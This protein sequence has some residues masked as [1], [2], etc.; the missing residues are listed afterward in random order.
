M[1][2][3]LSIIL[4]LA[5]LLSVSAM[6]DISA[7][8]KEGDSGKCGANVYYSLD[9]STGVLTISGTGDMYKSDEGTTLNIHFAYDDIK[10]AVIQNGVT[11][12]GDDAFYKSSALTSVTVPSS[13]KSIGNYALAGCTALKSIGLPEG[14]N[15]IGKEAFS[16]CTSL[17]NVTIPSTLNYIGNSAFRDCG[18]LRNVTIPGSV[19]TIDEFAFAY[20]SNLQ[21]ITLGNGIKTISGEAFE[22][23]SSLT[24]LSIPESVTK[25]GLGAVSNCTSLKNV[26]IYSKSLD[27]YSLTN[28]GYF[29]PKGSTLHTYRSVASESDVAQGVN[30]VYFG[31]VQSPKATKITKLKKGKKSFSVSWKKVNG[32]TG[33]QIQYSLKKNMKSSKKKNVKGA[34][35]TK[36]NVKKL[37]K[38]KKYYVRVRTYK[39]VGGKTYY[40]KW[41]GKESV[42]VK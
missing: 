4:S 42:K 30:V 29:M 33:Y 20:C 10:S 36:L 6:F 18:S 15:S 11:S 25:I 5:M 34:K 16:G 40:S 7:F 32:V 41:S 39:K 13:V 21:S 9:R 37:K 24:S 2:K 31:A 23:C 17:S 27:H 1:K 19:S 22:Y 3:V 35:K 14:L 26:Y 38:G 12:I 8:A 28:I